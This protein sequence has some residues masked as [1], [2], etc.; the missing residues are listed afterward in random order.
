MAEII[1]KLV[2]G[3]LLCI[4][5]GA[6]IAFKGRVQRVDGLMAT[7]LVLAPY[8]IVFGWFSARHIAGGFPPIFILQVIGVLLMLAGA[9]GYLVSI[10]Y[11]R[12]NWSVSAAIKEGHTIVKEG[13]FKFVRH[14]MYFFMIL[15]VLGSGLLIS[16]Y[17][18]VL[19]TPI[20]G[21]LYYFRAKREEAMLK[22]FLP[23]Y[24]QYMKETKMI[25]PGIF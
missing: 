14:P 8:L 20:V 9:A 15:V 7:L 10:A 5:L 19:Y 25:V 24:A 22:E 16:N 2:W 3:F 17:M 1:F 6:Q 13:T 18:I 23:G 4:A 11:L 12:K 21:F